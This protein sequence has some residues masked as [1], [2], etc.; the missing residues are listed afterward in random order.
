MSEDRQR[1]E[2]SV[3]EGEPPAELIIEDEIV[4]D[5]DPAM[6]GS[7]SRRALRRRVVEHGSRV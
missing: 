4:G 1:P 2:I 3:P 7:D 5:G 6:P